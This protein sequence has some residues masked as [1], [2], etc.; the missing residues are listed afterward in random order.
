MS[1]GPRARAWVTRRERYGERG[2]AG[3]YTRPARA[4]LCD[5]GCRALPLLLR[6]HREGVLSE[7]QIARATG[8]DRVEIRRLIDEISAG[9]EA[10]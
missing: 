4:S 5:M 8:L 1:D 3:A 9:D 7:G 6:L 10:A 2:H